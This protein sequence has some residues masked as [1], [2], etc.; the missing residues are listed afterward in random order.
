MA[1]VC[2]LVHF[3]PPY[4]NAG[5]ERMLHT[6]LKRLAADGH[7]VS[8]VVTHLPE[9]TPESYVHDGISVRALNVAYAD[10]AVVEMRPH[11]LISHH[12]NT[13]RAARLARKLRARSVLLMHNDFPATRR[14]LRLAPDLVVFNTH[15]MRDSLAAYRLPSIVVHPPVWPHE[16]RAEQ[17]GDRVTLIN[18]NDHKGSGILYQLAERMPDVGLLGV[19]GGHGE[20]IVRRDLGNCWIADHTEDMRTDVWAKTRILV[21]PSIYESYGMVGPEAMASGIP[22][23]ACPTPGLRESLG[24]AG[25]FIDDRHDLD[26]WERAIR[27]LLEPE[28]WHV[29]SEKALRRSAELDPTP[30]LNHWAD[31]VRRLLR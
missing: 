30:E 21:A 1:N 22:V 5:S 15:W 9:D 14:L 7:Q 25:T 23:I 16:H 26:A 18:L 13:V 11:L 4:R 19:I 3:Y 29:A 27:H 8:V 28:I 12:D 20:Q 2:A 17:T 10:H 24:W 6:M 31:T